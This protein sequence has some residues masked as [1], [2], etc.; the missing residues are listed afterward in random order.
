[1]ELPPQM[2]GQIRDLRSSARVHAQ[3]LRLAADQASQTEAFWADLERFLVKGWA[4]HL[5]SLAQIEAPRIKTLKATNLSA[6][7]SIEQAIQLA[8]EESEVELRRYPV[9]LEEACAAAELHL[10]SNSRHPK[11]GLENGFFLLEIDETKHVARLSDHEG[12]L[13]ELPADVPAVVEAL[14]REHSRVLGRAFNGPKFLKTLRAQ[15]KAVL[16]RDQLSDG[17]SVP[18]ESI[19]HRLGMNINSFRTDEFLIDLSKLA[20]QGPFEIDGRRLVLQHTK[21]TNQEM[22]LITDGHVGFIVFKEA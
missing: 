14:R 22:F 4:M 7:S 5:L 2:L 17:D 6:L 10:D 15:Y 1:M 20:N 12:R 8:K 16:K 3:Q 9:I 21:D 13:A 19:T 11:Y 18:I